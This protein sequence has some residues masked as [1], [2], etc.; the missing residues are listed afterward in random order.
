MQ[1]K[2]KK[3]S[4]LMIVIEIISLVVLGV[5]L[6][7]MQTSL[8]VR[9]Q[10]KDIREKTGQMS[11]L[12]VHADESAVQTT[13]SYDEVYQSKAA[14]LAYM[15]N[16]LSDFANT[17]SKLE[18]YRALL[19]VTNAIILDKEG[20]I[21]ASAGKSP[22]DFTRDRYNQLRG[23][24][25]SSEAPAAF[26][27]EKDGEVRRYYGA[28][29]DYNTMAVIE[30]DPAELKQLLED[31]STW[32]SILSNV[33]IGMEG[34]A[35]AVSAKDYS[36]L[37]HPDE[38]LI[39]MDALGA[40]IS[41]EELEDGNDT[42]LEFDGKRFYCGITLQ[43]DAYIICAVPESEI[44]ASRNITVG[45]V[46][47]VFFAV[48]TIVITYAI[49]MM[50]DEEKHGTAEPEKKGGLVYNKAIGQK[51][52]T[53]SI[54]GLVCILGISFYMQTLFSLSR[55]SM[56]NNQRVEEVEKTIDTYNREIDLITEQYNSRYLNKGRTAAYILSKEPGLATRAD[57][58]EMSRA[59]GVD[60]IGVFDTSGL[61]FVTNANYSKFQLSDD[62]ED[63]S[64]EFHKLL[65][66]AE[67][68]IQEAQPD[69]LSGEYRQYIGVSIRDGEGEADGFVQIAV[70]P[71]KLE[72]ALAN[73]GI[74][75]VLSGVKTGVKG[76]AFAV[77]KEDLTFAYYPQEKMIGRNALDYGMT[78]KQFRDGYSDYIKIGTEKYY[79]SSLETEDYYIY[80][81]IPKDE[82]T[83]TRM[84][85]SLAS[86]GVSL[87]CLAIVFLLLTLNGGGTV[88]KGTDEKKDDG[89]MI[90]VVMPDG[91]KK[92]T[93][94]AA[95]RWANHSM[96][97]DEK[98]PEQQI[99]TVIKGLISILALVICAS[100]VF[101]DKFFDSS[102]I[103]LYV[104]Q[105]GWQRG[106]NI[107]AITACVMVICVVA[108][109]TMILRKVLKMLSQTFDARGETVC[110]L[111][112][113]FLKYVSVIAALYYCFALFGVDTKTLLASAGILSLV[114]GLGAKTLVSDILAGLFIIFEGEFR[115]G[116]IVTIGD[117]RGT[118]L[119]IGVRTTKIEEAGKN[120]KIISNSNVNGVINMT[121]RHSFAAC[122]VG[123]EYGESLERVEAILAKELPNFKKR[124]HSIQDG[125]FYKGVTSLGDSSV[126]IRIVA[127]CAESDRMQLVRDLNR[128][129]KL[130]FDKYEINIPFPQI[131]LNQP[132]E[133]QEATAREKKQADAFSKRQGEL[134]KEMELPQD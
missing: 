4:I 89:P 20:N 51:I 113:S 7:T 27:V 98:T 88:K 72:K 107:F 112:S 90:D 8:S 115:V 49:L 58:A 41:V 114:I 116:D 71:A 103:F 82:M 79:G 13:A 26:E 117:W 130:L 22:A 70:T 120:I 105:G 14:S 46:L 80:V 131:V 67:Y 12:I 17:S 52:G 76:F 73:T 123:I 31:T 109:V 28:K 64:Y 10:R 86:T 84:P 11:E 57:L 30:Q 75:S 43:D 99:M 38:G 128:E 124:I 32:K 93:E 34:Y 94:S 44:H 63:Q 126:N 97:W 3:K 6:T 21:L 48:I 62:P 15:A 108:V 87:V 35:F 121:R 61:M 106:V 47:F 101:K 122:D 127:Q 110:R 134:A 92:K 5:F 19:D 102:S 33:S 39:G 60:T 40:G 66:G 9:D 96:A 24:F 1:G 45:I 78:E 55:H 68:L 125:P 2:L 69:E 59:I 119:E 56:S 91:R 65:N 16:K 81:V 54:I 74:A 118:V 23:V 77:S 42:W 132:S 100:V 104:L 25:S 36:F 83:G 133:Y 53:I 50:M 37:Y 129:M 85:I 18:E 29:I 95:A 111:I